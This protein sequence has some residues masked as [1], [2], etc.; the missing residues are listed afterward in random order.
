MPPTALS[1]FVSNVSPLLH[2]SV[3][4]R[5]MFVVDQCES[6]I[7]VEGR[8]QGPVRRFEYTHKSSL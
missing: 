6:N 3:K 8:V 4:G 1:V 5:G 7:L 2:E